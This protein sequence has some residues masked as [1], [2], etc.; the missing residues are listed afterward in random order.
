MVSQTVT[1][2][3]VVLC[4]GPLVA[5][6]DV[7]LSALT[8]SQCLPNG[9]SLLAVCIS[10]HFIG[11]RD[12]VARGDSIPGGAS[13]RGGGQAPMFQCRTLSRPSGVRL[14]GLGWVPLGPVRVRQGPVWSRIHPYMSRTLIRDNRVIRQGSSGPVAP[15]RVPTGFRR[16]TVLA[17]RDPSGLDGSLDCPVSVHD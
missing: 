15:C 5:L 2:S 9:W 16:N 7:W 10:C 4:Y 12:L 11:V 13:Q 1:F 8:G 6:S 14:D 17:R 3:Q